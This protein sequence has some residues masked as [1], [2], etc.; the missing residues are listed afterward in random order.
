MNKIKAYCI[1][2][3]CLSYPLNDVQSVTTKA[4]LT[5]IAPV[6]VLV[7]ASYVGPCNNVSFDASL[8]TGSGS[9]SWVSVNWKVVGGTTYHV[10]QSYLNGL[11]A[12][13]QLGPSSIP[14]SLIEETTYTISLTLKNFLGEIGSTS[15]TLKVTSDINVPQL[16]IS[17]SLSRTVTSR[18]LVQINTISTYSRCSANDGRVTYQW[19]VKKN[20]IIQNISSASN[21]PTTFLSAPYTF[22][23]GNLYTLVINAS[24]VYISDPN[25]FSSSQASVQIIVSSGSIIAVLAGAATKQIPVDTISTF[26]ASGSYDEDY[27]SEFNLHY[28][29]TC[30]FLSIVK[31]GASC[32]YLINSTFTNAST[33]TVPKNV[34][35]VGDKYLI[36][37]QVFS[38]D[39]ARSDTAD[40]SLMPTSAGTASIAISST[41][42]TFKTANQ[43][44]LSGNFTSSYDVN[45]KW[46]AYV[47]NQLYSFTSMT[48]QSAN[49]AASLL[50]DTITFPLVVS[51]DAFSPGVKVTFRLTISP[52]SSSKFNSTYNAITLTANAPPSGGSLSISPSSGYA[53]STVFLLA[54]SGWSTDFLPLT[55]EF[56]YYVLS[57]DAYLTVQSRTP[58]TSTSTLLPVGSESNGFSVYIVSRVYDAYDA[59]TLA[60]DTV[61]VLALTTTA[62]DI[63]NDLLDTLS[64]AFVFSNTNK[65]IQAINTIGST[66]SS[67]N[68]SLASGS[69]CASMN[70]MKCSKT[71]NTCSSCLPGYKG[72]AG[73][74]NVQCVENRIVTNPIGSLCFI[75]SN[76]TYGSCR[77]NICIAPTKSCPSATSSDCSGKGQCVYI[78]ST[79]GSFLSHHKCTIFNPFCYAQCLCD[80]DYGGQDCSLTLNEIIF[81][82]L[83]RRS[84][85]DAL[86][87][88]NSLIDT[89]SSFLE[90]FVGSLLGSYS[91]YEVY[92][93][94]SIKSCN[95]ALK[96]LS[97]LLYDHLPNANTSTSSYFVNVLSKYIFNANRTNNNNILNSA[98]SLLIDAVFNSMVEGQSSVN[99]VSDNIRISV[100]REPLS[101]LS[102]STLTVPQTIYEKSYNLTSQS[103]QFSGSA[104]QCECQKYDGVKFMPC[105]GCNISSYTNYNVTFGCYDMSQ[106][107]PITS[108]RQKLITEYHF[109]D[110]FLS[111]NR[112]LISS[113]IKVAE[114]QYSAIILQLSDE[115][116]TVIT[117]NPAAL[118]IKKSITIVTFMSCLLFTILI[119]SMLFSY[120]D[121]IDHH[122]Y[123]YGDARQ[124]KIDR[125]EKQMLKRAK[126]FA[127]YSMFDEPNLTLNKDGIPVVDRTIIDSGMGDAVFTNELLGDADVSSK[128]YRFRSKL[129]EYLH[130][131]IP[132]GVINLPKYSIDFLF[133]NLIRRHGLANVLFYTIFYTDDGYC[134]SQTSQLDCTVLINKATSTNLCRWQTGKGC[135]LNP[136]PSTV[137]F[138]VV[139]TL[140][141]AI[142]GVPIEISLLLMV[143]KFASKMPDLSKLNLSTE[144][145][146]GITTYSPALIS[147]QSALRS[148]LHEDDKSKEEKTQKNIKKSTSIRRHTSPRKIHINDEESFQCMN[149]EELIVESLRAFD[150]LNSPSTEVDVILS[151]VRLLLR[152]EHQQAPL[153]W[154]PDS[155]KY[156]NNNSEKIKAIM[157][158]LDLHPSGLPIPLKLWEWLL[159]GN[160]RNK[161]SSRLRSIHENTKEIIK[162]LGELDEV[163]HSKQNIKLL[164]F[165]ILEHFS[166]FKTFVLKH[167]MFIAFDYFSPNLIN[168]YVWFLSWAVIIT[169][170]L[171]FIYW[172][173]AWGV[174]SGNTTFSA[175]GSTFA[176]QVIQDLF[177]VQIM[178][179]F[180]LYVFAMESI[181]PQ[182]LAIRRVLNTVALQLAQ[183]QNTTNNKIANSTSRPNNDYF[184]DTNNK[185]NRDFFTSEYDSNNTLTV[186]QHLS[187]ACRAS[188]HPVIQQF[189][190]SKILFKINDVD[191][192][193][194]RVNHDNHLPFF[195]VFI[196]KIPAL[197]SNLNVSL[198]ELSVNIILPSFLFAI[199]MVNVIIYRKAGIVALIL[200]NL[201]F[202][203]FLLHSLGLFTK[204]RK[205]KLIRS[206]N[207]RKRTKSIHPYF[208]CI[209]LSQVY[210]YFLMKQRWLN[211]CLI[212]SIRSLPLL[213]WIFGTWLPSPVWI[214]TWQRM[215]LPNI[216][217]GNT[218]DN[219]LSF[220]PSVS[221]FQKQFELSTYN[222]D[223]PTQSDRNL[224][225]N[226]QQQFRYNIHSDAL[227]EDQ[228]FEDTNSSCVLDQDICDDYRILILTEFPVDNNKYNINSGSQLATILT[229]SESMDSVKER[230][231][232]DNNNGVKS[233]DIPSDILSIVIANN[234]MN[235]NQNKAKNSNY[236]KKNSY[237]LNLL[238]KYFLDV[239]INNLN[240][241]NSSNSRYDL[242][243]KEDM[244]SSPGTTPYKSR[245]KQDSLANI[246]RTK[247]GRIDYITDMNF[248]FIKFI[249]LYTM[250]H[251]GLLS[252]VALTQFHIDNLDKFNELNEL[253]DFLLVNGYNPLI[254]VQEFK[255][256]L[257]EFWEY[258]RPYGV[259]LLL[260]EK[261]QIE[262]SIIESSIAFSS[263]L[264]PSH[265]S[266]NY[267]NI[268]VNRNN[269][270]SIYFK[271]FHDWFLKIVPLI[272]SVRKQILLSSVSATAVDTS[273]T[274]SHDIR[275][276]DD[277]KGFFDY[278]EELNY[279]SWLP[280]L[281]AGNNNIESSQTKQIKSF[282]SFF[283]SENHHHAEA[284]SRF[285]SARKTFLANTIRKEN[286]IKV[287]EICSPIDNFE[288]NK[289]MI[290]NN[291]YDNNYGFD[292]NNS[293]EHATNKSNHMNKVNNL[294][295]GKK[296]LENINFD[297][298]YVNN[299]ME[300]NNMMIN[301]NPPSNYKNY[302]RIIRNIENEEESYNNNSD[303][304][305][306]LEI[307]D[308]DYAKL[309]I[310]V[311][312]IGSK[313]MSNVFNEEVEPQ[314][315]GIEI[316]MQKI[317]SNDS[318]KIDDISY[319][320]IYPS[321]VT[322]INKTQ[323]SLFSLDVGHVDCAKSTHRNDN[324]YKIQLKS[325]S[326][327]SQPPSPLPQR[328]TILFKQL[329]NLNSLPSAEEVVALNVK[330]RIGYWEYWTGEK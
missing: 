210:E 88:T 166:F 114:C 135:S 321:A 24:V 253:I 314:I 102:N 43:L 255:E 104:D 150:D 141:I 193:I 185:I 12:D 36:V 187:P 126:S 177:F 94:E 211:S 107:C 100:I 13:N 48:P 195:L 172:I 132:S 180:L 21:N 22:S 198:G 129:S 231:S 176:I 5:P 183:D 203:H 157:N 273:G 34:F 179:I 174:K 206:W 248:A 99:L 58:L 323:N 290:Q 64:V 312:A 167:Q 60:V 62:K 303:N 184:D 173:F 46:S 238:Y 278:D 6:P 7:L 30:R 16:T 269:S 158:Q 256:I 232:E 119:G 142:V 78:D 42:T 282:Y 250:N 85:C 302:E 15:S 227:V 90:S 199:I 224:L 318:M 71:I 79:T 320:E 304:N 11:G 244:N 133:M 311:T 170:N 288:Y 286:S 294:Y 82:D 229:M 329:S 327:S 191:A 38:Y 322:D 328:P 245:L 136:P 81:R 147:Y 9:R 89:S 165:F 293:R 1:S 309:K 17:G 63:Y 292:Y 258:F 259:E 3:N 202:V 20:D 262:Q 175:W 164:Q 277:S 266:T 230:K 242:Y 69:Y 283:S 162:K 54:M 218:I 217:Q 263:S 265:N 257:L 52:T 216:F 146:F 188:R 70:I 66:L 190:S 41:S 161:M 228:K 260:K 310:S 151:K 325:V 14:Q 113:D 122:R 105:S 50:A 306:T 155:S 287:D 131:A 330:D 241:S 101:T 160:Y 8:S 37:I 268:G 169:C 33:L 80:A 130:I 116:T 120:W 209:N 243:F 77:D 212:E 93:T 73:D 26:D 32:D 276:I 67:V 83:S 27:S 275:V 25:I 223:L 178:R 313:E 182:M 110:E 221:F 213:S 112:R 144:Y 171:F 86:V 279:Q 84:M 197:L 61:K 271:D 4:P 326:Q 140:L 252:H 68:C 45:A 236:I 246:F 233:L 308:C 270:N 143:D 23:V 296:K 75:D 56:N 316:D 111:S 219:G 225:N 106:I 59:T 125:Q 201:F 97:S 204:I 315:D 307:S 295:L 240:Y 239:S 186:I 55:Y 44:K 261:E 57:G 103:L 154:R 214:S 181:R 31:Y 189:I 234:V 2:Q 149:Y 40:L 39:Y 249:E 289:N 123:L 299:N 65:A 192:G 297:E 298:I 215:N 280:S 28:Q 148:L 207:I 145:W 153:T 127:N 222:L 254:P 324:F 301:N 19:T 117:Y 208:E 291:V 51:P 124:K 98:S 18:S 194:C 220:S 319:A 205:G 152:N 139:A 281:I 237:I 35:S 76:C 121:R 96:V 267:S 305:D 49:F 53:I 108:N 138:F 87:T 285:Y 284:I 109:L 91:P 115:I 74:S 168:P 29:W 226:N 47:S 196:F 95:N 251:P 118:N 137:E 235:E 274:L 247:F 272:P 317:R 163:D 264:S 159:Y 72:I 134:E 300:Y 128:S 92:T 156:R 200:I 10:I